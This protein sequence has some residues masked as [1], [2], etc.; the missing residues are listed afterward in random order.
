MSFVPYEFS[1][2]RF[3]R[4]M[5]YVLRHNPE[6]YGLTP[7]R[8]GF[9]DME[10]F[11]RIAQRR[12]PQ[13]SGESLRQLIETTGAG[14]FELSG[15]R[16]RARYGHSI[17]VEPAGQPVEPPLLLYYGLEAMRVSAV[18]A[19]GLKPLDRQMLHLSDRP[20]DAW[21]MIRKKTPYPAVV[22]IDAASASAGGIRFYLEQKVYLASAIPAQ[23]LTSEPAPAS[24]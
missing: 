2:E 20:E 21:A 5:A 17:A 22:R 13:A 9:V 15:N 19:E 6:R 1:A 4:W 14:R 10:E 23:F 12:Y 7:D 3:S 24:V 18:L 16:L 11:L 8:H